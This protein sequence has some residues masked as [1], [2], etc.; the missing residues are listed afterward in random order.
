MSKGFDL[1]LTIE[2]NGK[3]GD[4]I[5]LTTNKLCTITPVCAETQAFTG[6]ALTTS[7]E[8][9]ECDPTVMCAR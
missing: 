6:C 4:R 7:C 9:D 1:D 2:G 8:A 3:D 5:L